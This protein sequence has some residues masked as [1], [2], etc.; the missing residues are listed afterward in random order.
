MYFDVCQ[1]TF[2]YSDWHQ[3]NC[4]GSKLDHTTININLDIWTNWS[5]ELEDMNTSLWFSIVCTGYPFS[6]G[7]TLN[8][9]T[10]SSTKHYVAS[11]HSTCDNCQLM[12]DIGR[13]PLH[14]ANSLTCFVQRTRMRLGDRS[15]SAGGV[16]FWYSFLWHFAVT[17]S[18]CH[19]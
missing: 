3:T 9:W 10:S 17:A 14:S 1:C 7:L 18:V 12:T 16:S 11:F 15:F 5:L 2:T 19:F 4:T 13:R 8:F 6:S